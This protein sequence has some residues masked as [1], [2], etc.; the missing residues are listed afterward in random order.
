MYE[1]DDIARDAYEGVDPYKQLALAIVG[2]AYNDVQQMW[3]DYYTYGEDPVPEIPVMIHKRILKALKKGK[4]IQPIYDRFV[5]NTYKRIQ[6]HK[7]IGHDA[8]LFLLGKQHKGWYDMLTTLDGS[9]LVK[10]AKLR[11]EKP[12]ASRWK[13]RK[14]I[15]DQRG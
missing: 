9:Y 12:V 1:Y 6:T 4:P 14:M 11:A 3:L 5:A 10:Q 13:R 8:E 2:Q 15:N 7:N